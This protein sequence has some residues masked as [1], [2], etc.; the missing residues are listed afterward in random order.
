MNTYKS[1]P[2]I[3]IKS[4][5][6]SSL[7]TLTG[8]ILII[9]L[10]LS[11]P[12]AVK[13]SVLKSLT[14][15][16]DVLIPSLFPFMVIG[17]VFFSS[18]AANTLGKIIGKPFKR[19]FSISEAGVGAFLLGAVCGLPLGG[20]YALTLYSSGSISKEECERLMGFSSNAGLGFV[21]I[22]VGK[23][24]WGDLAFGW[25]LYLTQILSVIIVGAVLFRPQKTI[26]I[27][28]LT[29]NTVKKTITKSTVEA[30]SS[31]ALNMLRVCAFVVIFGLISSFITLACDFL[32]LPPFFCAIISALSEISY[33]CNF[34]HT[35]SLTGSLYS[36]K[37]LTFFAI[38]FSGLCA[39]SQ[40]SSMAI[41]LNVSMKKY[42]C[43]R[44]TSAIFSVLLGSLICRFYPFYF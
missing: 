42:Y 32:A 1:I 35:F 3:S 36:A 39:H 8:L 44:L 20:K 21:V 2:K 9:T 25:T 41:E 22:G 18:G 6:F 16:T 29:S 30:V 27:A 38:T 26:S 34:L 33:A 12:D 4:V 24:I 17:E 14:L 5:D 23:A 11:F 28:P 15:C 13:N 37:I 19:I 31:S 10:L 40:L 7:F 43:I